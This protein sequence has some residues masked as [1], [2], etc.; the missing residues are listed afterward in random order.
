MEPRA[1]EPRAMEPRAMGPRAMEPRAM[2]PHII[3]SVELLE[4]QQKA[5][6]VKTDYSDAVY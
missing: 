5:D 6:V 4:S 2:E 1:M 3:L